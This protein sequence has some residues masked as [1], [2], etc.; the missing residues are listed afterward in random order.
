MYNQT[1]M[2]TDFEIIEHTADVGIL[3]RGATLEELFVNAARGMF[4]IMCDL[5][6]VK[7][8]EARDVEVSASD[9]DLLLAEWLS[10][11]LFLFEVEFMLFVRFRIEFP[12]EGR[13]R[14]RAWGEKV[15]P[16]RHHVSV[17]IKAVTHHMLHVENRPDGYIATVIFDI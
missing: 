5:E 3:A 15:N 14:G 4:S 2:S 16:D 12:A 10:E 11:L 6:Q 1:R 7:D 17:G 9:Q 8:L 13:L